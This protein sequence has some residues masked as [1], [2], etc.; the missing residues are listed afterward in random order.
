MR[1]E[2]D[3]QDGL[4]FD[5]CTCSRGALDRD[6]LLVHD[7]LPTAIVHGYRSPQKGKGLTAQ[8]KGLR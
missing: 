3:V 5:R 1:P 7:D 2:E 6:G 8:R 4:T